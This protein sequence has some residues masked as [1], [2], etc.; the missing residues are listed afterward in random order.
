VKGPTY[1]DVQANVSKTF[2]I[3][4]RYKAEFKLAAYNLLNHLNLADPD[5]VVTDAAFGQAVHQSIA[6][7]G[8]QMEY[9]LRIHF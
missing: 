4:E 7:T 5:L 8:R 3:T 6:T 9:S 1:Y 2:A